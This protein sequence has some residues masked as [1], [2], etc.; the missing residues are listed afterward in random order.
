MRIATFLLII[1]CSVFAIFAQ[2]QNSKSTSSDSS[3]QQ[4]EKWKIKQNKNLFGLAKPRF[5]PYTTLNFEKTNDPVLK[6]ITKGPAVLEESI[7]SSGRDLDMSRVETVEKTVSYKLQIAGQSD[8]I[9]AL[10]SIYAV[11]TE[12]KQTLVGKMLSKNDRDEGESLNYYRDLKGLITTGSDSAGWR[13]SIDHLVNSVNLAG[14]APY[15]VPKIS[16]GYLK[17]ESD[18]LFFEPTDLNGGDYKISNVRGEHFAIIK[19][20]VWKGPPAI[21]IRN[22]IP[23]Q[24][25]N[26]ISAVF[27]VL[28]G[29]KDN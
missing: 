26:A 2:C 15:P 14:G 5:G 19:F 12:R 27:A 18:S 13:F 17:N 22:D 24:Y 8:T 9:S 6:K 4:G 10:F 16:A 3:L 21:W 25:Q 20:N 7:G 11:S 29:I 23:G 28:I 1:P